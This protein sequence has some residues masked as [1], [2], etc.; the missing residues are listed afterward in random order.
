MFLLVSPHPERLMHQDTGSYLNPALNLLAG[1]GFSQQQAPPYTPDAIRTPL[2]SFFIV[3]LYAIFGQHSLI[4]AGAQVF[5]SAITAGL[6]YLLGTRLL[7]EQ[8]ARAGGSLLALSLGSIVYALYI[9]T[10]TL[11]TLLLLGIVWMLV[12]YRKTAQGRW[13]VGGGVLTGLAAL[14]R[15]IALPF[16]LIAAP[17][18]GFARQGRWYQR[19]L[20]A[21]LLLVVACLVIA[22]WMVRNYRLV[23]SPTLSTIS[24]YN[25]LF[26]NAVSLEADL[27]GIGQEQARA[28]M[29]ERVREELIRRGGEGDEALEIRLYDEWA[30]RII[31]AHPWRYLYIHL[32]NDL[33]SL[34][35]NATEFL[36]LLGVT[37]GGRG[38]LSVLNQQGLWAAV[39]HYFGGQTWVLLPL[40]PLMALLGLTYLGAMAGLVALARRRDWFTLAL[41]LAPIAYFLL[42]PG[43]PS[44]PRFRV[45]VMPYICLLAGTGL[46][47]VWHWLR[48]RLRAFSALI[49]KGDGAE[50]NPRKRRTLDT[51]PSHR[52]GRLHRLQH[53]RRT[54]A[55][56]RTRARAR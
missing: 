28:E 2:Y 49:T 55:A 20:T 41:L 52:R 12:A 13:L 32:K 18:A 37:Q 44:H 7:P 36:E 9:L 4:I 29:A 27:R 25:L 56:R 53:R 24:S 50:E 47:A 11:F 48:R 45:P 31:L 39:R 17:L 46:V 54:C 35:P 33:N 1:R 15:P 14:C 8:E 10:E 5:L 23:G 30:R 43:A 38:T 42:I 3:A 22:P 6:T 16:L 19:A 40:V 21:V 26:Y 34:L 51:L